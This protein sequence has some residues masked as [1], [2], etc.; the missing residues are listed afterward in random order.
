MPRPIIYATIPRKKATSA[1]LKAGIG[2]FSGTAGAFDGV[3]SNTLSKNTSREAKDWLLGKTDKVPPKDDLLRLKE[4][5]KR[6]IE[7]GKQSATN[8]VQSQRLEK[9]NQALKLVAGGN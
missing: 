2:R 6:A 5:A 8:P 1:S 3:S 9:I 4:I 7:T